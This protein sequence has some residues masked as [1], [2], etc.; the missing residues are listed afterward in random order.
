MQKSHE[1]VWL[2]GRA[3]DY[4]SGGCRFESCHGY[5]FPPPPSPLPSPPLQAH[6]TRGMRCPGFFL[7]VP[8]LRVQSCAPVSPSTSSRQSP[9]FVLCESRCP[10]SAGCDRME[11]RPLEASA[12]QQEEDSSLVVVRKEG[13]CVCACEK[14]WNEE[15]EAVACSL[16]ALVKHDVTRAAENM[17]RLK[18]GAPSLRPLRDLLTA[19]VVAENPSSPARRL[20]ELG[21]TT[22]SAADRLRRYRHERGRIVGN[23]AAH[24][25]PQIKPY[26]S[27]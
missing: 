20:D 10:S 27:P 18:E 12:A 8:S 26:P 6:H 17:A 2:N 25:P 22:P 7:F 14:E 15:R 11:T 9:V 21:R 13:G 16:D 1:T 4:G 24:S 5:F 19:M 23:L 3:P